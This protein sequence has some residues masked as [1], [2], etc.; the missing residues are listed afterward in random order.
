MNF[1]PSPAALHLCQRF[2]DHHLE[3]CM[4]SIVEMIGYVHQ[5]V[6]G[7][8]CSFSGHSVVV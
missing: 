2:R 5:S 4:V 3:H 8:I 1:K 7:D 6:S